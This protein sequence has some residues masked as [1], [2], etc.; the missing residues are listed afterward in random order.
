LSA[1]AALSTIA[2]AISDSAKFPFCFYTVWADCRHSRSLPVSACRA[3]EKR[4]FAYIAVRPKLAI[5]QEVMTVL[6]RVHLFPY[7]ERT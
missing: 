5:R 1:I 7:T 2:D 6:Y 3:L 4:T